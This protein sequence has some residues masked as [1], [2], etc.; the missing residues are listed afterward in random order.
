MTFKEGKNMFSLVVDSDI[1]L[2]L[3][4]PRLDAP[5]LFQLIEDSRPELERWLPWVPL[6][7]SEDKERESLEVF[8][9]DFGRG[10]SL[11]CLIWY[12]NQ[13]A[14]MI[15]FNKF[16]GNGSADIG[17]WLRTDFTHRGIMHRAVEAFIRLGFEEYDLNK[18]VIRAATGNAPSNAVIRGVGFHLDGVLPQ[19]EK[20]GGSYLDH[21]VWSLLLDEWKTRREKN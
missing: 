7:T 6:I 2:S 18:I 3:P 5:A 16:A 1:S 11:N 8:L 20:V 4:R 15:S 21:N 9:A 10:K 12:R 14:G 13:I 17:Y 19:E